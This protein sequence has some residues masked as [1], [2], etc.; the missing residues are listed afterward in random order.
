M[1]YKWRGSGAVY[2][3]VS[4]LSPSHE[5]EKE[6]GMGEY[7]E[8]KKDGGPLL[9]L[10]TLPKETTAS[11]IHSQLRTILS[12]PRRF[13]PSFSLSFLFFCFLLTLL[14]QSSFL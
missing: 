11:R 13:F 10:Q 9:W 12:I 6:K 4:R 7:C 2:H 1:E 14:C 8:V 3:F 5:D